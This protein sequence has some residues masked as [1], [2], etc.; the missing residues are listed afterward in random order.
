[1]YICAYMH[2]CMGALTHTNTHPS[3]CVSQESP[4]EYTDHAHHYI[5]S[6]QGYYNELGSDEH[7]CYGTLKHSD[8]APVLR[9]MLMQM[10]A[11]KRKWQN[12]EETCFTSFILEHTHL[13]PVRILNLCLTV[14]IQFFVTVCY[15]YLQF[16]YNSYCLWNCFCFLIVW[17]WHVTGGMHVHR[18][19]STYML[20]L[21]TKSP[22]LYA[23]IS[24]FSVLLSLWILNCPCI[25]VLDGA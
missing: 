9:S 23:F 4:Y 15:F 22:W 8:M 3:V 1:M 16:S 24:I 14:W 13:T 2:A 19:Y 20:L 7:K 25:D 12:V 11:A 18:I 6:H 21:S 10:W 5:I 17:V